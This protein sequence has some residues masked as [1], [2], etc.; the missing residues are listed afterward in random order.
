MSALLEAGEGFG[1]DHGHCP[2]RQA[3]RSDE[4]YAQP[5]DSLRERLKTMSAS[6]A[7]ATRVAELR[8]KE[9]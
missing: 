2:L 8:P 1:L 9:K 4:Q 5:L 7:E 6:L 3:E